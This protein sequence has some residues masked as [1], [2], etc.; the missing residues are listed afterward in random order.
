MALKLNSG[1]NFAQSEAQ[2]IRIH[3]LASDP[4]SPV[5]GQI[6]I[7][8]TSHILKVFNGTA[9]IDFLA[10]ANH[11]GTQSWSTLTSTPTTIAG[12]GITDAVESGANTTAMALKA[13]LA[14]PTFTGTPVAPTA[15]AA[16]NTTQIATTAFVRTE[17]SNLIDSAPGALDTLNELAAALG[18]DADFAGTVT[19]NLA[20]KAPL[21]SPT[22]TGVPA[23]PTAT[24]GTNTTQIAT[25]AFV[26]AAVAAVSPSLKYSTT[27]GDGVETAIVVTHN[28]GT[29]NVGVFLR[30]TGSPYNA[31]LV[32]YEMT[33]TNTVTLNFDVAPTSA[34]WTVTI[35]G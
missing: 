7:N 25:T 27:V 31:G 13:P 12:Y 4:G 35:L 3:N 20:A 28:L 24:G 29:R 6:W 15:S 30:L 22:F 34:Q 17:I 26:T 14:S 2:N 1:L 11:S 8:T 18:D 19:T 33:T 10:R 5:E 32:D 9:N 23:A 21:A 16:T